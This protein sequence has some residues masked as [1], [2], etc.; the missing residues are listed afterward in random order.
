MKD[1]GEVLK[2]S[3]FTHSLPPFICS[4]KSTK[5]LLVSTIILLFKLSGYRH[6]SSEILWSKLL[7]LGRCETS[8]MYTARTDRWRL[9]QYGCARWKYILRSPVGCCHYSINVPLVCLYLDGWT[10]G[11]NCKLLN[12]NCCDIL[13]PDWQ[14]NGAKSKHRA[15]RSRISLSDVCGSGSDTGKV[16]SL[17]WLNSIF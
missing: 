9:F 10:F 3:S 13:G 1:I 4:E 8:N 12:D 15:V 17:Q 16:W 11:R 14:T 6:Q 5:D 2:I 7:A